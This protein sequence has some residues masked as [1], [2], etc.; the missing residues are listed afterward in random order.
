MSEMRSHFDRNVGQY[1]RRACLVEWAVEARL[2]QHTRDPFVSPVHV[3]PGRRAHPL[4]Q[5]V[6]REIEA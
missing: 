6:F 2:L 3:A 4:P 1:N 5:A